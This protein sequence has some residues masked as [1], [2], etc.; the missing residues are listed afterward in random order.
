MARL[1]EYKLMG[2]LVGSVKLE[3]KL[4]GRERWFAAEAM[5]N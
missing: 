1:E 2:N 4:K 3:F 5:E